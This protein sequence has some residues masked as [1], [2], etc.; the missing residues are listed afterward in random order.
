MLNYVVTLKENHLLSNN[1]QE[2]IINKTNSI[3]SKMLQH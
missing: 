2:T 3:V 1:V